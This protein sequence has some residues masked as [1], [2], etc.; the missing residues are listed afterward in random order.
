M[1]GKFKLFSTKLSSTPPYDRDENA[2]LGFIQRIDSMQTTLL[3][4]P[5]EL[6]ILLIGNVKD[7]IIGYA[8]RSLLINGNAETWEM[9]KRVLI[10]NHGKK[11]SVNEIID[12]IS[13]CRCVSTIENFFYQLN[14]LLFFKIQKFKNYINFVHLLYEYASNLYFIIPQ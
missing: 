12:I 6:Q 5:E 13:S 2:L 9:I 3:S 10:D 14:T 1:S 11:N 8:R 7:K 4:F